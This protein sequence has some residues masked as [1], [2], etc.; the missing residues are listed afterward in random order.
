ME[1]NVE[2]SL[3]NISPEE[4]I[5]KQAVETLAVEKNQEPDEQPFDWVPYE[6]EKGYSEE[7][8]NKFVQIYSE[9]H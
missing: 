5:E 7:E 3:E 8:R 2:S 6:G 9:N 1:E 4:G